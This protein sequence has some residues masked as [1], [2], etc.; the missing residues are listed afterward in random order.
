MPV[1]AM[2]PEMDK[3]QRMTS[4]NESSKSSAMCQSDSA[5]FLRVSPAKGTKL[6]APPSLKKETIFSSLSRLR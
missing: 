1:T 2:R 5:C 6:P 3:R 4:S